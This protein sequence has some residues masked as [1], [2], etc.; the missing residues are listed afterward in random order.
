MP[1]EVTEFIDPD[2]TSI[3]LDVDWDASG[4]GMPPIEFEEDQV[5]ERSGSRHRN[6]RHGVRELVLPLW[7]D[8]DSSAA[9]RTTLRSLMYTMDPVRGAGKIRVTSELG[10]QREVTCRYAA[11]LEMAE[12]LGDTSGPTLQRLPA[13]FRVFDPYWYAVADN[14][15]SFETGD[16]AT[17]FPFFPL[18]L[19]SSEVFATGTI[20]NEGD[21]YAWPVWTITGPGS[22]LV[23]RNLTTGKTLTLTATIG[24]GE[25]VVID[26]REGAKTV[27]KNDGTNL[28]SGLSATS[29]LWS[30]QKGANAL[31][32]ELTGATSASL[33]HLAYR[34]RYL[35]V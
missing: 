11:G 17:F 28:F 21:V 7:V 33:V 6:T 9:L 27:T 3:T 2:G 30:L 35:M 10:D 31:Q 18:R 23:L 32:I 19:S 14:T 16:T 26:T 13:V 29:S 25:Q 34:P 22:V 24:A 1:D 12:K 8:A 15:A 5:P 20:T 4:R